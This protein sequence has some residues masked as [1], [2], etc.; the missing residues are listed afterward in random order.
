LIFPFL[1]GWGSFFFLRQIRPE[2]LIEIQILF[3]LVFAIVFVTVLQFRLKNIRYEVIVSILLSGVIFFVSTYTTAMV[4][5]RSK[6]FYLLSWIHDHPGISESKLESLLE[7][8]Y[9]SYDQ[10]YIG[11]RIEE[12]LSR[13]VF[14]GSVLELRTS[15]F[16]DFLYNCSDFIARVFDL[17]GWF[18]AKLD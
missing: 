16:G 1:L 4:I 3:S 11:Q 14:V 10:V 13:G 12:Q 7:D 8:K 5:D 18:E 9:G 2:L 6:S 15:K 17:R